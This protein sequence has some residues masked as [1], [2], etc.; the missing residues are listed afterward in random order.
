MHHKV[1]SITVVR[2]DGFFVIFPPTH[3]ETSALPKLE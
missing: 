1:T 3:L 2:S